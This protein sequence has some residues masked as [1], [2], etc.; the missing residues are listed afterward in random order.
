MTVYYFLYIFFY[1]NLFCF[2]FVF[3]L[4]EGYTILIMIRWKVNIAR[5]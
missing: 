5:N 3:F 4:S 2:V 1:L